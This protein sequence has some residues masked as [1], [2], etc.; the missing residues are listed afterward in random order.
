MAPEL[1]PSPWPHSEDSSPRVAEPTCH[2][3]TKCPEGALSCSQH[4][5]CRVLS[6][7]APHSSPP[8]IPAGG[9]GKLRSG[10]ASFPPLCSLQPGPG[11]SR[12]CHGFHRAHDPAHLPHAA[13]RG[14]ADPLQNGLAFFHVIPS[15][16]TLPLPG[17]AEERPG[18]GNCPFVCSAATA[19]APRGGSGN[20]ATVTVL[21]FQI[22]LT[23]GS[24]SF[25][26]GREGKC[27]NTSACGTAS[28][29]S[30]CTLFIEQSGAGRAPP[31]DEGA[32]VP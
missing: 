26:Q 21:F 28:P 30:S 18:A 23:R 29:L 1:L 19:G 3:Q 9:C 15:I 13:S 12:G 17:A 2:E 10:A 24:V 25:G 5:Q 6:P 32:A 27:I 4:P 22:R 14:R 8:G 7:T 31:G 11:Q 16:P 20:A